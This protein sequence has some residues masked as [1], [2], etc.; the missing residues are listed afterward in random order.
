MPSKLLA[1]NNRR[2][3]L[4]GKYVHF[5]GAQPRLKSWG[6]PRTQSTNWWPSYKLFCY[7]NV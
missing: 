7:K 6:W 5:A 2:T 1:I 4:E 3:R